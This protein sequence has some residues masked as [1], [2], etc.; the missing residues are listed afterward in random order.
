MTPDTSVPSSPS[1]APSPRPREEGE[2]GV[3]HSHTTQLF[4]VPFLKQ[5]PLF[6]QVCY[7]LLPRVPQLGPVAPPTL[8]ASVLAPLPPAA[9]L[10]SSV[11][12][13]TQLQTPHDAP[14]PLP[15]S[16]QEPPAHRNPSIFDSSPR[17][18][19]AKVTQSRSLAEGSGMC[20]PMASPQAAWSTTSKTP[21]GLRVGENV[22]K[23]SACSAVK[24]RFGN[25]GHRRS[26]LRFSKWGRRELRQDFKN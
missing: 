22:E 26:G 17:V 25:C 15:A 19:C 20:F 3:T 24:R 23:A 18:L 21:S 9:Q 5:P 2:A 12:T 13:P 10:K 14:V 8:G 4:L 16:P 7:P 11:S 1:S 6:P